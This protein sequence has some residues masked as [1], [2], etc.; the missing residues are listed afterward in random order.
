MTEPQFPWHMLTIDH[1]MTATGFIV[2]VTSN[3]ACH[4]YLRYSRIYPRIHRKSTLRRG[5]V[6][7]WD[8]RFCFVS[9]QHLEQDEE[10]DTITHTFTWPGWENCN[11]RYFYF[12]ATVGGFPGVSDSPIFWMHY[13]WVAPPPFVYF[14]PDA[15]PET[16]SVDGHVFRT[17]P[18]NDK[19]WVNVHDGAGTGYN[20]S[21]ATT[22]TRFYVLIGPVRWQY[23]YRSILLFDTSSIPADKTIHAAELRIHGYAK[24]V[25]AYWPDWALVVVSSN[26][27]SNHQL[28]AADY[29]A[30][31]I[32]ALSD[33]IHIPAFDAAG[34]NTFT[35]NAAGLAAIIKGGITKLGIR[36]NAYDRAN[37]EPPLP[38]H[39]YARADY[40][41]ADNA[42]IELKPR[43]GVSYS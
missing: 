23:I 27:A 10:G 33:T 28:I 2:T 18:A 32:V 5:V 37:V 20:D 19:N 22:L 30:L 26:P 11:T 9:Y 3:R 4:M 21:S 1:E 36:E 12:F 34:H 6:F 40:R 14:Y 43:L 7:G 15:H 29:Q 16:T 13:L 25:A 24:S 8:A 38:S 39:G 42:D 31:G 17:P 41:S 35:F